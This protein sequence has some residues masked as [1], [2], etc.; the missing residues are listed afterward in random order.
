[1]SGTGFRSLVVCADDYGM[2]AGVSR[3]ILHLAEAGRISATSCMANAPGWPEGARDLRGSGAT[4]AVGLHL[5]LTWGAPLDPMPG[6]ATAAGAMPPLG[7]VV[8]GALKGAWSRPGGRAELEAEIG[9]Q[10][11]RFCQA[12][13]RPPDFLD[14]HQH[15]HALP[16][17]RDA[18]LAVLTG[19]GLAGR[20]W[21]RD[22]SERL[23][24]ILARRL[25]AP[26]A[27]FVSSLARGFG[28]RARQ[29]G[30]STNR[31]FSGFSPFDPA[32]DVAA[33]MGAYLVA[34]GPKPLVMCHPGRPDRNPDE[35]AAARER[36]FAYLASPGWPALLESRGLTLAPAPA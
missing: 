15:V 2:N 4:I 13:G 33:D 22:P 21:L 10:L 11:D 34:L 16:G 30:F 8:G 7:H 6:F 24:A 18:L 32:R 25:A 35:I 1:M 28:S 3:G 26:K 23:A 14:G 29:A 5:T 20:L 31:G 9:R 19:Q 17:I 27:A 36:E 12:M